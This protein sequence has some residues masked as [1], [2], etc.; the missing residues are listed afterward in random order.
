[1]IG[2]DELHQPAEERL[3]AIPYDEYFGDMELTEEEKE[4]RK[5]FSEE[6]EDIM[7]FIFSL[8]LVMQ[9]YDYINKNY[10]VEQLRERYSDIVLRYMDMDDYI[11]DY[12]RVFSEQTV[13][14]T[15]EH[16]DDAYYTSMDRAMFIS[17]NE[18]NTTLNHSEFLDAIKA[19]KT[20]KRWVDIRDKRERK[21]HL[22]VGGAVLPIREPFV[23]GN[24]LML[25]AKDQ[26]YS[27]E[28]KEV[29]NCRCTTKYY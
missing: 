8:F 15:I 6:F 22:E 27:P 23:V 1:M 14:T 16:S 2:F 11:D 21:T 24:S 26:T 10:M 13:E 3:R 29:V 12:I 5:A 28:A 20:K 18:A 19:G 7:L 9:E 25:Y 17:E 4:K